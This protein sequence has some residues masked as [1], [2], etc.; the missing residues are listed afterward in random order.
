MAF[1]QII[2]FAA[3]FT[4]RAIRP[5][6]WFLAMIMTVMAGPSLAE[7]GVSGT[8]VS[9][10]PRSA[11]MIFIVQTPDGRLTGR[12][13]SATLN[14]TGAISRSSATLEG[15]ADG[16]TLMLTPRSILLS[17]GSPSS[18]SGVIDG[19][20]LNLSWQGGHGVF[21]RGTAEQFRAAVAGMETR[22]AQVEALIAFDEAMTQH[23]GLTQI[24]DDIDARTPDLREGL[25]D[26]SERYREL[27]PRFHSRRRGR[28]A[29][30]YMQS[31]GFA[32]GQEGP[33]EQSTVSELDALGRAVINLRLEM[34]DQFE[35]AR[36]LSASIDAYCADTPDAAQTPPCSGATAQRVRLERLRTVVQSEFDAA[37]MA[38]REASGDTGAAQRIT[39]NLARP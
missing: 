13:E 36:T 6:A 16:T 31:R 19:D 1:A 38:Y 24:A 34:R 35:S 28:L 21:R 2:R 10:S 8:Y 14:R 22:S 12:L 9:A 30:N 4:R 7:P 18:F 17:L 3:T 32:T 26:A 23:T 33:D 11:E 37:E 39:Q 5:V 27:F 20:D 15:A 29:R 25:A